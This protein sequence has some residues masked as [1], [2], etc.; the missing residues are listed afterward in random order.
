[1]GTQYTILIEK[2]DEFIRKFYKNQLI[3][4]LLYFSGSALVFLLIFAFT[5]YY[6]HFNTLVRTLMFYSYIFI[7]IAIFIHYIF[8]PLLNLNKMGSVISHIQVA[9]I[10]GK[11]FSNIEDKLLNILQ[12]NEMANENTKASS[13]LI[14]ASIDQKIIELK[15]IPFTN[16]VNFSEN[17]K[18]IK[19]AILPLAILTATLIFSP[20]IISKGTTRIIE[21]RTFF[22]EEAPFKFVVLNNKL[23]SLQNEDYEIELKIDGNEVPDEVFLKIGESE[24]KMEK[25]STIVFKHKLKNLQ[26][27]IQFTFVANEFQSEDYKI[28]VLPNPVILRFQTMLKYPSYLHKDNELVKNTGDLLVP[29]GTDVIWSFYTSNTSELKVAFNE[30]VTSFVP[31]G[32]MVLFSK[33]IRSNIR[34]AVSS[35]NKFVKNKDSLAYIINVIPDNYPEISVQEFADSIYAN[36]LYFT[37]Q[38]NDDYGLSKLNFSYKIINSESKKEG[39]IFSKAIP[40]NKNISDQRFFYF[41]NLGDLS[42]NPGDEVLY[43]FEVWDNDGVNGMKSSKSKPQY[44]KLPT[45]KEQSEKIDKQADDIKSD[46]DQSL[47]MAKDLQKELKDLQKDLNQKKELSWEEKKKVEE[48][49]Q[50]QNDLQ[51]KVSQLNQE[52]KKLNKSSSDFQKPSKELLEK[53]QQLNEL[54]ENIMTDEMK[55]L[56]KDL[57]KMMDKLDKN[58]MQ[59]M[60]EKMKLSNEDLEKE[61]DR[62]LELFKQLEFEQKL[63]KSIEDLKKLQEKEE[64]LSDKTKDAKKNDETLKEQQQKL[65]EEFKDLKKE[66]DEMEKKNQELEEPNKLENTEELEKSIE[67]EMKKSMDEMS[68]NKNSKASE[69]QKNAAK[70]MQELGEKMEKMQEEMS[71]EA[72]SEDIGTLRGILENLLKL[73]F[74]QEDLI[75]ATNNTNVKDPKYTQLMQRQKKLKDDSKMI[76][77]SLFALSKRVVEIKSIVNREINLIDFNIDKS[78]E[79]LIDRNSQVASYRQQSTMTSINN[80]ALL[81]NEALQQM[82]QQMNQQ[83]KSKPGA[84]QCKKPGKNQKPGQGKMSVKSMRQLQDQINKQ[85]EELKKG[86]E[87]GKKSGEGMGGMSEKLAKLAAQQEA[88]RNELKKLANDGKNDPNGSAGNLEKIANEMEQTETDLVNKI[89]TNETMKRQQEILTKLLEAEK[90]ER[91]RDEEEK[92]ESKESKFEN[93][94]NN[95]EKIKYNYNKKQETELLKKV[96]P[97]FNEFYKK[98]ISEYFNKFEGD[99]I[100]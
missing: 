3:K 78:L 9:S 85:M 45:D 89:I 1:M 7:N 63:Q 69:S 58:K 41:Q 52:N 72:Q 28:K 100:K 21:H 71:E 42:L 81:L 59:D 91:E 33:N 79:M 32:N 39:E 95:L 23:E 80:L 55:Q 43:Y 74:E 87:K 65:N 26:K 11:H 86:L 90:S 36:Q 53:Q 96:P 51:N 37:G 48:I 34:Y 70:K 57:E 82:Q 83:M 10:I 18:Y 5:E 35:L 38:I 98:K 30:T 4:G 17:K 92:R 76:E 61:L 99:V 66:M 29:E 15:P 27:D 56:F 25:E 13:D 67:D 19:Y 93:F 16:A 60:I 12:L 84:G 94:G 22:K 97:S 49:L 6:G 47:K 44:Y 40:I 54:F 68:K 77:D 20:G 62:N 88:I 24:F 31:R 75:K 14:L 2:L 46:I 8:T 64:K 73:S 50:K